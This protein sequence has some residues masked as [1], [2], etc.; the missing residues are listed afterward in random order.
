MSQFQVAWCD[1]GDGTKF[2]RYFTEGLQQSPP[3]YIGILDEY[4]NLRYDRSLPE[5][6]RSSLIFS[7]R[8]DEES[9]RSTGGHKQMVQLDKR[10]KTPFKW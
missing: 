6:S 9:G 10:V 5:E 8:L 3:V 2:S 1:E 4:I 7:N